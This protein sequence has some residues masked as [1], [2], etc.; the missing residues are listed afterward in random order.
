M[1]S[2]PGKVYVGRRVELWWVRGAGAVLGYKHVCQVELS[3]LPKHLPFDQLKMF[4]SAFPMVP[5][6]GTEM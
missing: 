1:C 2:L 5:H 3:S 6:H 4:T